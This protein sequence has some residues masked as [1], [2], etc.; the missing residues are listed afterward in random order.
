MPRPKLT[1]EERQERKK[2]LAKSNKDYRESR[3]VLSTLIKS[4][5]RTSSDTSSSEASK[6]QPEKAEN[7]SVNSDSLRDSSN[8]KKDSSRIT[9][10]LP[11]PKEQEKEIHDSL[12]RF[13]ISPKK[14]E[15]KA[16]KF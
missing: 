16:F 4:I 9:L 3:K 6:A 13:D 8:G 14:A 11:T 10:T 12:T 1:Y 15:K 5:A 7:P 2:K